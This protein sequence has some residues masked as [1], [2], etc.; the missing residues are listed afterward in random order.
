M[1]GS[2]F[3]GYTRAS[4]GVLASFGPVDPAGS[5]AAS[6]SRDTIFGPCNALHTIYKYL[7]YL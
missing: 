2:G 4:P 5:V 3:G 7:R 6:P 1:S